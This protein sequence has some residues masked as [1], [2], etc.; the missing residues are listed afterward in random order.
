MTDVIVAE[1]LT[2]SCGEQ[3]G[4]IDL[5]LIPNSGRRRRV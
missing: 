5:S 2:K 3:H 4:V 1:Q